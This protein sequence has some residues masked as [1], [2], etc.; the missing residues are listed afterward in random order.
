[1]G[2]FVTRVTNG[3]T[4]SMWIIFNASRAE[5]VERGYSLRD[6][7]RRLQEIRNEHPGAR[8]ILLTESPV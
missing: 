7:M 1:M 2:N 6:G 3:Q 8:F 4:I 5:C